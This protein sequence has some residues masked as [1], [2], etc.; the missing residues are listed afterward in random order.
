MPGRRRNDEFSDNEDYYNDLDYSDVESNFDGYELNPHYDP[1]ENYLPSWSHSAPKHG[2]H[3][4]TAGKVA[5]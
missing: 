3:D 1:Y 5:N 2:P 4:F